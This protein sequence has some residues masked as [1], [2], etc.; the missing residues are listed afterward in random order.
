MQK[1]KQFYVF[2]HKQILVMLGLSLGPGIG[3]IVLAAIND[4]VLR[5]VTWYFSLVIVSVWGYRLYRSFNFDQ[6]SQTALDAWYQNTSYFYYVIFS[7]WSL[8]FILFVPFDENN[9]HYVAIFTQVGASVVAATLLFSDRRLYVPIISILIFPLIFY[10]SQIGELYGYILTL[11]SIVFYGVLYYSSTSSNKLLY[12]TT[13]QSSH[14]QLTGLYNRN[15]FIEVMQQIINSL[16][17]QQGYC[18][19]LLIDLDHFKTI[20]DSLGHD[21]G[22]LLLQEVAKRM[23]KI[24]PS[25]CVIARM[26]G[27][28]FIVVGL[29][30]QTYDECYDNS[31]KIAEALRTSLKSEYYIDK[32]SLYISASIGISILNDTNQNANQYIKE[33]DIAMYEVKDKG[34]DG[35]V[36]FGKEVATRVERNLEIERLLHQGLIKNEFQL[37]F[38]P[39]VDKTRCVEGCEVL[40]RWFNEEL[41]WISPTEFIPIAE[42][43]G[44][45]IDIGYF[46]IE[47]TFKTIKEW[48]GNKINLKQISI[49]VSI[50][51][52][53]HYSFIE[54]VEKLS[55]QYLTDALRKNI[56]FELTESVMADEIDVLISIMNCL[57]DKGF[58]F[59]ID[60]FGTGYSSLSYLR[61]VPLDEIK[62]DRSFIQEL[63]ENSKDQSMVEMILNMSKVFGLKVVAEGIETQEQENILVQSNCDLMQ[64][65]LFSKPLDKISFEAY[66]RE[67]GSE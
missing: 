53:Y 39:Q 48:Q 20:N 43:T 49:N 56:V 66:Y 65:Y 67:N 16:R 24:V 55:N 30:S 29:I 40:L 42:K 34:R 28:E 62:I 10:F 1:T 57:K 33:A 27:D 9:L 15:Y 36:V 47:E 54:D 41:G 17:E 21:V 60:D 4:A 37:N 8:I 32:H 46:V 5:A 14:D 31:T 11:F 38:Q 25:R 7:L 12:K 23:S 44:S 19:L 35:V 3:Y 51:Q 6:M 63:T 58:S 2:L 61:K 13:Y 18:S 52:F 64:G 26:G 22:D 59:S 50:R 45:I